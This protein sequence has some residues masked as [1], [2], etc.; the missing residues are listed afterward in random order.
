ML[1]LT[2]PLLQTDKLGLIRLEFLFL[3]VTAY[4]LL[5][6]FPE[7]RILFHERLVLGDQVFQGKAA[8]IDFDLRGVVGHDVNN[9][10]LVVSQHCA[11]FCRGI[12]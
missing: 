1:T 7:G 12:N 3:A 4:G 10:P 2:L 6:G 9:S 8:A 11:G 5:S